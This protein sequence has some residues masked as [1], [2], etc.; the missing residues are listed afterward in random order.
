MSDL[1]KVLQHYH[2]AWGSVVFNPD[3]GDRT[4][5]M[6][7]DGRDVGHANTNELA[8]LIIVAVNALPE[9]DALR[10]SWVPVREHY[11]VERMPVGTSKELCALR[12]VRDAAKEVADSASGFAP[13]DVAD[14]DHD[15]MVPGKA[16][17]ALQAA[18]DAC[19]VKP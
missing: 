5:I 18:L 8:E 9:L 1:E 6:D 13:V 16:I 10:A 2:G 19:E 17:C 15:W 14:E 7:G 11:V 3:D 12:A 4:C